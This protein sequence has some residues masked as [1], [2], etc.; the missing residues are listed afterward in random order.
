M[1]KKIMKRIAFV[2][3]IA[4]LLN[5]NYG[6]Q[7]IGIKTVKA[8][9]TTEEEA[10]G[11]VSTGDLSGEET[12]TKEQTTAEPTSE[13]PTT[14]QPPTE[15]PTTEPPTTQEPTTV[16]PDYEII[17][18]VYK[19]KDGELIE[20]LGN[21]SD[22]TVTSL[23]IPQSVRR[24]GNRVFESCKYIKKITFQEGSRLIEIGEY[25][26]TGCSALTSITL[27]NGLQ[28]IETLAF[29]K[30]TSLKSLTIPATVTEGYRILGTTT[31]VTKVTF[32]AGMKTIPADILRAAYKVETIS[33]KSGVTTIG[34]RAFLNC[35]AL[36]SITIP[37]T[38]TNIKSSAFN[39]CT[40]LATVSM[41]KNIKTLGTYAFKNCTS[42]KELTLTKTATTFGTNVFVGDKNLTL[43]VY[44]NSKAKAY[45]RKNNI[46]WQYTSSELKRR[47]ASQNVY[48]KYMSLVKSSDKNKY[49]LK[50]LK[51]YVPQGVCIVG[52][53]LIVSMY[54]K[55]LKKNSILLLYNKSTGK[56]VKKIVLPSKDHVSSITNVKGK[57]VIGLVNIST[58]DYLAVISSSKLKKTKSG[59]KVK[60]DYKV[61]IPGR[62]DFAT[63]DGTIFWAGHS[64]NIS[65][66]K[67]YG[68][69]VKIK[70]KKLTFT[71]KYSYTVPENTQGVIVKKGSGSKRTF[72]FSQSYGRLNDSALITYTA[73]INK[74]KTLGAAKSTK[75][76]PSMS[77]GMYMTSNGY[78]YTV[79]ESAAGLY[80]GDP[81]N[82]SE[83][84]VKNV[85]KT[86]YSDIAK[87][88]SK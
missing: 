46:K 81:D 65:T 38:V 3:V 12:G 86:K 55:N 71:K 87:L 10:N 29:Q 6:I 56:Y 62:A 25:A 42:L 31:A 14:E 48:N 77:E 1:N 52:N 63:F 15:P 17:D 32:T 79:F 19:V 88:Q 49:Q 82:T 40:A 36:K 37:A 80:C 84:Q 34:N 75:L 51:N 33:L 2:L 64:A 68:Y 30:C 69:K 54:Y 23:I 21:K 47:A 43:L 26:F 60:Y 66:A 4:M 53:Y 70:K 28:K 18:G 78:V 7:G 5:L 24:I 59:K 76:L 57:L 13:P 9:E 67:M 50:N 11:E 85:C 41:S 74:A 44:A 58:T 27:P 72:V 83:I 61:K 16:K 73:K 39:G 20:Y 22:K 45:A 8:A 35:K